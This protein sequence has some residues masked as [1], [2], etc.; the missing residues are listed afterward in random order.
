MQDNSE[1]IGESHKVEP[2]CRPKPILRGSKMKR[3][4]VC[5]EELQPSGIHQFMNGGAE[6]RGLAGSSSV[7]GQAAC[8]QTLWRWFL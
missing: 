2:C 6:P 5:C 7:T 4:D 8:K 3:M 1:P